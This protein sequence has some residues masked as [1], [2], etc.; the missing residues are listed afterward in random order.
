MLKYNRTDSMCQS[1]TKLLGQGLSM[2]SR[3]CINCEIQGVEGKFI[4]TDPNRIQARD[5]YHSSQVVQTISYLHKRSKMQLSEPTGMV[6]FRFR[7]EQQ[8]P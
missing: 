1:D 8:H 3:K 4:I 5:Y 7:S 2:T 6:S